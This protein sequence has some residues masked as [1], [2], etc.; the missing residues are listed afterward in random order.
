M[1]PSL[2]V[3]VSSVNLPTVPHD[4]KS[5]V[6]RFIFLTNHSSTILGFIM[7]EQYMTLS[8]LSL[9]KPQIEENLLTETTRD[10]RPCCRL[11][12]SQKIGTE[13]YESG[14]SFMVLSEIPPLWSFE[15][16]S[17]KT[18]VRRSL[19]LGS[20]SSVLTLGLPLDSESVYSR[21]SSLCLVRLT[22]VKPIQDFHRLFGY[23]FT[24]S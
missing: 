11:Q 13:Y 8:P 1:F 10:I 9:Y 7:S 6:T 18:D 19:G 15:T 23:S 14:V 3:F 4:I 5:S 12:S 2:H 17:F 22:T 24:K 20:Y 21:L 16:R